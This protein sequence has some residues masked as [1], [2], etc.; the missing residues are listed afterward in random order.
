VLQFLPFRGL[1]DAPFRLYSGHLA[2][3]AL[4]GVLGHQLAWLAV[5]VLAGRLLLGRGLRRLVVQGG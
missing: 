1:A 2:P 3:A 5:L 4:A